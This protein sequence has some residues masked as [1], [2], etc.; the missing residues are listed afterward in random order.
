M[1][2]RAIRILYKIRATTSS[3]EFVMSDKRRIS[4][5]KL[6]LINCNVYGKSH[7][8]ISKKYCTYLMKRAV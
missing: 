7:A 2:L 3:S 1:P 6:G 4:A 8:L 5:T